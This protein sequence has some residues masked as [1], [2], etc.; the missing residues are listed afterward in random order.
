MRSQPSPSNLPGFGDRIGE[1]LQR[2]ADAPI[3]PRAAQAACDVGLF[4]DTQ[5]Q[6]DLFDR[7]L[8]EC[9]APKARP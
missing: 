4:G 3:K 2:K 7:L 9:F 1:A 8:R 5:N 6:H